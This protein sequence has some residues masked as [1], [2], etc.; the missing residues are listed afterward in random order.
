MIEV[1]NMYKNFGDYTVLEDINF[2]LEESKI[3]GIVGINGAG[4][5]TL[6]RHLAGVYCCDKGTVTYNNDNI[7]DNIK[8]KQEIIFLS[9]AP[10]F[11][12]G[13]SINN[14]KK[15]LS[16]YYKFDNELFER[17]H[18]IFDLDLNK[19]V[20][21]FSKG[22]KKQSELLLGLCC[23]PKVLLLDETFDGLDPLITAKVKS[24]LVDLVDE[25]GMTILISS[26]NLIG[27][28]SMCDD[29]FLLDKNNLRL[30]KD[31]NELQSLFKI[32]LYF[33]DKTTEYVKELLEESLQLLDYKEIGSVQNIVVRGLS[34][35]IKTKINS[36]NPTI[37]DILEFTFE[38][39]FIYELGG[40]DNE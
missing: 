13:F 10:F 33:Q 35:D 39:R 29:I 37:F 14:M 38:E 40:T 5:S 22:M 6:I 21:K 19:S 26:H 18:K 12:R 15:F 36:L 4:K 27:L 17:L 30:Q 11:Y 25:T 32:Q 23:N 3:Y 28:D 31:S 7:Y 34:E 8:A 2:T 1:K 24:L 20:N 9:D 16:A